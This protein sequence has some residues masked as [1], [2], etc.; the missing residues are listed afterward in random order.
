M[1]P[2]ARRKDGLI[3]RREGAEKEIFLRG[4]VANL[5]TSGPNPEAFPSYAKSEKSYNS[6]PASGRS[7]SRHERDLMTHS[8]QP[9]DQV[10]F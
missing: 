7:C 4:Q 2:L 3:P 10:S 8:L 5:L 1:A 6:R 9:L